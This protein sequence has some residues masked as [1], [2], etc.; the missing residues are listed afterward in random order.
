MCS[1]KNVR[2]QVCCRRLSASQRCMCAC[3]GRD[4][5][6]QSIEWSLAGVYML[7]SLVWLHRGDRLFLTA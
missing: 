6:M 5:N 4:S 3:G 2:L 1:P 7:T